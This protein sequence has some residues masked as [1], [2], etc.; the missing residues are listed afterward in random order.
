VQ[1]LAD[2]IYTASQ[3]AYVAGNNMEDRLADYKST[4]ESLGFKREKK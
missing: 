1:S 3:Y 2:D 4:I